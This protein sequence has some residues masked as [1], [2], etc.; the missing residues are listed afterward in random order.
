M[1][2]EKA[3]G[4]VEG[5]G[6]KSRGVEDRGIRNRDVEEN[7]KREVE[8]R[9]L[10]AWLLGFVLLP[11]V[12]YAGLLIILSMFVMGLSERGKRILWLCWRLGFG[13]LTIGLLI[14][15]SFAFDKGDGFLQLTNFLP[16]FV[17]FGVLVTEPGAVRAP[18]RRLEQ[19]ARWML[20]TSVPMSV[21][22][23]VEFVIKF[24]A[25]APLVQSL[26]LPQSLLD[27]IYVP[28]F[29][30]RAHSMFSHP[31]GLA[32]YAIVIFGLG[33]GLLIKALE[34]RVLL[35]SWGE[36]TAVGLIVITI[37]CTGSR[38]GV[39]IALVLSAIA[40]VAARR[41]KWVLFAGLAGGGAIVAAVLSLGIGGR[42]L[43]WAIFTNDPRVGVWTLAVEMI[44]QRPWLGWGL[45]GLRRLYVPGS[46]YDYDAIN[47]AH[48]IWLMLAAETGIPM[49]VAF[50]IV[51]G[52]IF[53]KG[54]YAYLKGELSSANRAI[55]LSYLLAFTACLLFHVFDIALFDS[56]PNAIAWASLAGVY[57]LSDAA[58]KPR[59][60]EKKT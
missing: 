6:V 20:L 17:L 31:N 37:F 36:I 35:R 5:R 55:L 41:H 18:F 47:H 8:E 22:A 45:S 50:S 9:S 16:F 58:L 59:Y 27:F 19:I 13:W 28:D 32:A 33:L 23:I 4:D 29:G 1:T 34:E 56:R 15:A 60:A 3:Y 44:Q 30:H 54:T 7:A 49:M 42:S 14:S 38:N 43:S 2:A 24:D 52:T 21:L 26:P 12:S 53:Y 25:I 57:I 40:M 51:I 10:R 48:N 39:L 11:Y 46:I